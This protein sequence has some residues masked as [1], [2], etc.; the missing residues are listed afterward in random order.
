VPRSYWLT[1]LPLA[2]LAAGIWVWRATGRL[3]KD[4]AAPDWTAFAGAI[5]IF[6]LAFAG[7][8]Y[9]I[10]P[11]VVIDRITLWQAASHPTAL[12]MVLIGVALVLPF[13]L[14]YTIFAHRVFRG[15]AQA[16]LYE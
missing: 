13:L 12:K 15:K 11:Y 10:F 5:S 16:I 6:A 8:A 4:A 7:L 14:G 9:S 1:L 2:T 3:K